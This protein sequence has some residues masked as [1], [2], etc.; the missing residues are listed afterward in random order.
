MP[1]TRIE[2]WCNGWD[3]WIEFFCLIDVKKQVDNVRLD[4]DHQKLDYENF[5]DDVRL[6]CTIAGGTRMSLTFRGGGALHGARPR[7]ITME[8]PLLIDD[9][10]GV[11]DLE[12]AGDMGGRQVEQHGFQAHLL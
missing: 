1:V 12:A 11:M 4:A 3:E 6:S 10:T 8:R 9:N 7:R 2:F 5:I